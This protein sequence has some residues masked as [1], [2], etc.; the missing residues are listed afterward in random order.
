MKVFSSIIKG[1]EY[2]IP[3][4]MIDFEI[5]MET[6][7]YLRQIGRSAEEI[8]KLI[9]A[10]DPMALYIQNMVAGRAM[11]SLN[12]QIIMDAIRKEGVIEVSDS[13]IDEAVKDRITDQTSDEDKAKI[14]Q[15][16]KE[17]LEFSKVPQYLIDNNT[18]NKTGD[19]LDFSSYFDA[20]YKEQEKYSTQNDEKETAEAKEEEKKE[21]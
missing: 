4:S 21:N 5:R 14:R 11:T 1:S 3:Q 16:A 2:E 8:D 13:E 12:Q 19:K 9:S 18:F 17:S 7:D 6:R 10:Q 20:Y 15:E